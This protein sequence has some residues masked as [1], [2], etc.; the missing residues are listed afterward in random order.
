V[1]PHPQPSKV[2]EQKKNKNNTDDDLIG[3]WGKKAPKI[4]KEL[5]PAFGGPFQ[6]SSS[7]IQK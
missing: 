2:L 6:K 1:T 3:T 5:P 7:N 4:S